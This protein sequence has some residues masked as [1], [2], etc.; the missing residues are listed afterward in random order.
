VI[1][2]L[3]DGTPLLVRPIRASDKAALAA[4]HSRLSPESIQ[5]RF[6]S[7]KPTLS[8]AE[9]RYLTEVDGVDHHAIVAVEPGNQAEIVAVGRYVRLFDEPATADA[10]IVVCDD[11]QGKGLGKQLAVMLADEAR[12]HG[13]TRFS[14]DIMSDNEPALKLMQTIAGRLTDG[15]HDH[16]IHS[17]V[18]SLA[19]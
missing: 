14:A 12:R 1:V 5:K 16:G 15:G 7:A 18:A 19:A 13:V 2:H 9:L 8:R 6:L 10:A 4:G 17:V 3:T 11:M